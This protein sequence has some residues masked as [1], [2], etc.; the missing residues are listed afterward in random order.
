MDWALALFEDV[1]RTKEEQI[2][3]GDPN[4]KSHQQGTN[5]WWSEKEPL[6]G[7]DECVSSVYS[8][9][10]NDLPGNSIDGGVPH[11]R[12][13]RKETQKHLR[14]ICYHH[15]KC[16]AATFLA[17]FMWTRPLN[18]SISAITTHKKPEKVFDGMVTQVRSQ[19]I[20]KCR[21]KMIQ[22]ELYNM[23]DPT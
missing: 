12:A 8:D 22:M 5:I 13:R 23:R 6:L 10:Q 2:V 19:M 1:E 18:S 15:I 4:L 11:K 14:K 21:T 17:T 9:N 16:T 3:V 7:C 20:N